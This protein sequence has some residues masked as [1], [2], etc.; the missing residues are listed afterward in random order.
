MP[1]PVRRFFKALVWTLGGLVVLFGVAQ[2][3][4][5]GRT[6][7]NP[8][9]IQEPAWDSPR[10]RELTVR[11]CFNCHS[12]ETKWPWYAD[13]A[14]ISWVV[15]FDVEV[16]RD[17]INFSEWNRKYEL[18]PYSVQ[19]LIT[20]NMPTAKYRMAHPEANLNDAEIHELAHGLEAT[21][22]HP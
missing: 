10:T 2:L 7:A 4:P 11:A 15:Q 20:G 1:S 8:P 13:V 3:I 16:A 12:N 22:G 5:Y 14:P 18:A 21:L 19:S 9:T 17:V 6:H